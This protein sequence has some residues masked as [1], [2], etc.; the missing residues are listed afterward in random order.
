MKSILYIGAFLMIGAG[1]YGFVDY[2]QTSK[3]TEF[4]K[5]YD[6]N[7]N[8][9]TPPTNEKIAVITIPEKTSP[10]NK[11]DTKK[12]R[13][14]K[15]RTGKKDESFLINNTDELPLSDSLVKNI[16]SPGDH[17]KEKKEFSYKLF[18]RAPLE[19]KYITKELKLEP[20]KTE[21]KQQ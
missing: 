10:E 21:N 19:K 18:S 16:L 20:A 17:D 11:A 1:I 8:I 15:K 4:S 12:I 14:T 9:T 6:S 3:K 2:K 5:M 13:S 7:D